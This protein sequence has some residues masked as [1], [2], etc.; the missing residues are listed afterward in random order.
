IGERVRF[1]GGRADVLGCYRA[2]DLCLHPARA[3]NTGTVLL[4]ALSQGV[5]VVCSPFDAEELAR[6]LA[7]LLAD[8]ELRHELGERGRDAAA[9]FPMAHRTDLALDVIER[10]AYRKKG[11]GAVPAPAA[12]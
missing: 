1:A 11:T 6:T 9:A 12:P 10:V 7:R 5:P 2:A 4:E 8:D 3:E